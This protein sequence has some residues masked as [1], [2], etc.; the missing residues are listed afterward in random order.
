MSKPGTN[1]VRRGLLQALPLTGA[2]WSK[3]AVQAVMLPAH[4]ENS[5]RHTTA[6]GP[7]TTTPAAPT[8]T[9]TAAPGLRY[10][11][12]FSALCRLQTA[13]KIASGTVCRACADAVY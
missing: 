11:V 9:T 8:T 5:P 7:M 4:A 3:P 13:E 2:A 10:T 1:T 6:A 12:T